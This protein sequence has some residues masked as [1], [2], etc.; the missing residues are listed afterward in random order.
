ME[1]LLR[2]YQK[3]ICY[4]VLV[5]VCGLVAFSVIDGGQ[6]T[7]LLLFLLLLPLTLQKG[8]FHIPLD[9]KW[10]VALICPLIVSIPLFIGSKTGEALDAPARYFAAAIC[11]IALTYYPIRSELVLRSASIGTILTLALKFELIFQGRVDWGVGVLESGYV[12]VVMFALSFSQFYT[13]KGKLVWRIISLLGIVCSLI[14]VVKTGSRG[15]WPAIIFVCLMHL[16]LVPVSVKKKILAICIGAIILILSSLYVPSIKQRVE[17]SVSEIKAYYYEN[18]HATSL[19]YRLDFWHIAIRSFME[20]PIWGVSYDRRSE[21]MDEFMKQYP[22][23][24]HIGNDGRSSSHNE[25]LNAMSK[26]GLLG[27]VAILMLYLVPLRFFIRYIQKEWDW[28]IRRVAAAGVGVVSTMMICGLSEAPL[29]NVRVATTYSFVLTSL[30]HAIN[31]L[32]ALQESKESRPPSR[33]FESPSQSSA[34]PDRLV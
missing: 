8:F 2:T 19:G 34:F 21:I 10:L 1:N 16:L 7:A 11:L 15:T 22:E 32:M 17:L 29:M 28:E 23:S 24:K 33:S 30:F 18:D 14:I 5:L 25:I 12:G 9:R 3:G 4:P 6:P 20:N 26:K 13:D 27:L 31:D